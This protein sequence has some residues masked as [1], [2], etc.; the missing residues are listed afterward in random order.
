AIVLRFDF[1][2]TNQ[3]LKELDAIV[4]ANLKEVIGTSA[5]LN[6][7]PDDDVINRSSTTYIE[8]GPD[9][10]NKPESGNFQDAEDRNRIGSKLAKQKKIVI[11]GHGAY[12]GPGAQIKAATLG[13]TDAKKMTERLSALLPTDWPGTIVCASCGSGVTTESHESFAHDLHRMLLAKGFRK[14]K[15]MGTGGNAS[16]VKKDLAGGTGTYVIEKVLPARYNPEHQLQQTIADV[17]KTISSLGK[18]LEAAKKDVLQVAKKDLPGFIAAVKKIMTENPMP[19]TSEMS[20]EDKRKA[21]IKDRE[22]NKKKMLAIKQIKQPSMVFPHAKGPTE[23]LKMA[24]DMVKLFQSA[25]QKETKYL[26]TL[27]ELGKAWDDISKAKKSVADM[28]ADE[29]IDQGVVDMFKSMAKQAEE[30]YKSL[31]DKM[32]IESLWTTYGTMMA[33]TGRF[34]KWVEDQVDVVWADEVD[35]AASKPQADTVAEDQ[36]ETV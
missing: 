34:S 18:S 2:T 28:E 7:Q 35:P 30:H 31:E 3:K 19:D 10:S 25:I 33:D 20:E 22:N 15:V 5:I 21:I 32:K 16:T 23:A 9:G 24:K 1:K 6:N 26:N 29:N 12:S 27:K 13:G 4:I 17:E 36:P 14:L 11:V 8:S